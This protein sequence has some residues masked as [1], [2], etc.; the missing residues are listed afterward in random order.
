MIP[1]AELGWGGDVDTGTRARWWWAVSSDDWRPET[2]TQWQHNTT[3]SESVI[4]I[5]MIFQIHQKEDV[6]IEIYLSRTLSDHR[7]QIKCWDVMC[8]LL[9]D[10]CCQHV[11]QANTRRAESVRPETGPRW[12]LRLSLVLMEVGFCVVQSRETFGHDNRRRFRQFRVR[13]D[14][15]ERR[16]GDEVS[17][18]DRQ[19]RGESERERERVE[20]EEG[21]ALMMVMVILLLN[22][23][24]KRTAVFGHPYLTLNFHFRVF[25]ATYTT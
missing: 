9:T 8:G 6:K 4:M 23:K 5:G 25:S 10:G 21:R 7:L 22:A 17:R 20:R 19:G 1:L 15:G 13:S 11:T 2:L 24:E 16:P 12:K 14:E 18:W 3:E